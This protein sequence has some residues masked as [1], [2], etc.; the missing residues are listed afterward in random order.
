V[1]PL[2]GQVAVVTGAGSGIGRALAVDLARQGAALWL[3]GRRLEALHAVADDA[4]RMAPLVECFQADLGIDDD[5]QRLTSAL[6]A[7]EVDLLVHSAGVIFLGT[8]ESAPVEELDRQYRVNARAPFVLTQALLPMLRARRG[9]VVFIN[10]SAAINARANVGHYAATKH[11]LKALADSLREE[12]NADGVR[13]L[14]VYPG[15]TATPMQAEI[16]R[17]EGKPYRPE[18]LVQPEDVAAAVSAAINLP[19]SAEVTEIHV[20]PLHKPVQ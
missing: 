8:V 2:K 11:A 12:V 3:V 5:L 20:R 14:T 6:R 16:H 10:S 15:R 7:V 17:L 18:L 1:T 4:R 19:R 13:V 9:Q